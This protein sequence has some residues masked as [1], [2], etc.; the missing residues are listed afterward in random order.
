MN[1]V[2]EKKEIKIIL[3][4]DKNIYF[5]GEEVKGYVNIVNTSIKNL[6]SITI[7]LRMDEYWF[8]DFEHNYSVTQYIFEKQIQI[9]VPEKIDFEIKIPDNLNPSF[10]YPGIEYSSFIRYYIEVNIK[11]NEK[12]YKEDKL[13]LIQS[14]G[15]NL[16]NVILHSEKT[17]IKHYFG[18]VN[19][20][21]SFIS[22]YIPNNN[23]IIG[24]KG[25]FLV[26]IDNT[27]C[28]LNIEKI[29]IDLIRE[30]YFFS[31]NKTIIDKDS[32]LR[33]YALWNISKGNINCTS[34]SIDFKDN[35]FNKFNLKT[36]N[37]IYKEI[38][39]LNYLLPSV[40]STIIDCKY[41]LKITAYFTQYV[42][43]DSR[44][45][46]IVPINLCHKILRDNNLK[47]VLN[48]KG[49][50]YVREMMENYKKMKEEKEENSIKNI[51]NTREINGFLLIDK[52]NSNT[53]DFIREDTKTINK[54]ESNTFVK[55]LSNSNVLLSGSIVVENISESFGE[56]K[57]ILSIIK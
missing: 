40:T 42:P 12:N 30:V 56:K 37:H 5:R 57:N 15:I 29:K 52:K 32:L 26:E 25:E 49:E 51:S 7:I 55:K 31:K 47:E 18:I 23:F 6:K 36:F 3:L 22:V 21:S 28:N 53:E 20:G 54:E 14:L 16:N 43:Y 13:I 1:N 48:E 19:H 17:E 11:K 44:P 46:V 33:C 41:F 27:F 4:E 35:T 2:I 9:S 45:R 38:T 50:L 34:F 8:K 24:E 10:E 39:N